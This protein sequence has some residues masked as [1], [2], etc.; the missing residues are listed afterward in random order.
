MTI[1]GDYYQDWDNVKSFAHHKDMEMAIHDARN[2]I[3][4]QLKH[5][6]WP[7]NSEKLQAWVEQLQE[8]LYIPGLE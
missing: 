1:S 4:T 8:M 6:E 7:E 3:R 2:F 5:G